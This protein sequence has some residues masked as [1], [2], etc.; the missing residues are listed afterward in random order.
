MFSLFYWLFVV[1]LHNIYMI[2]NHNNVNAIKE[3]SKEV[4][5]YVLDED[6]ITQVNNLTLYKLG[7]QKSKR[8][9]LLLSGA[10]RVTF[11]VYVQ[12]MVTDLVAIDYIKNTYQLIVCEKM[13]KQTFVS[14]KDYTKYVIE[15][16]NQI[17][18]DE[19]TIIG[20][21]T[22][23]VIASHIMHSCKSIICKKKIITYDTPY[24]VI[25]NVL[26]FENYL[27]YRPDY[28]FYHVIYKTY[29]DH[30]NYEEIKQYVKHEKWTDGSIKFLMMMFA[31]H[32]LT[33]KELYELSSFNFHQETETQIIQIYCK[34]DPIVNR[35]I[36]DKYIKENMYKFKGKMK[37]DCKKC[38]GHCSDMWSPNF[39]AVSVVNHIRS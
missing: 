5:K 28:Y 9:I 27:F 39:D 16:N 13:D 6:T 20:F 36:C 15:L 33:Y 32:N 11:D 35:E 2:I 24:Q 3:C 34:K 21:S 1:I 23:G 8:I 10:F 17:Q 22:G 14:I 38:I 37:N 7:N 12:K 30:Y 31:I 29:L 19:L 18:L 26:S 4:F 25:E